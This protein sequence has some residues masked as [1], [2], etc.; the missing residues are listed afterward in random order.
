MPA[1][2]VAR[3]GVEGLSAIVRLRG[4]VDAIEVDAV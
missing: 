4:F 1:E 3:G 2:R